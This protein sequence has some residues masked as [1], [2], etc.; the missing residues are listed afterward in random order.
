MD[1]VPGHR[2]GNTVLYSRARLAKPYRS[3]V[4]GKRAA[5][6]LAI[7]EGKRNLPIFSSFFAQFFIR[8]GRY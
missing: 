2:S 7:S 3:S 4:P 5:H 1:S 6:L 8:F